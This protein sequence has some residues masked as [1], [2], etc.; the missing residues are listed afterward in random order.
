MTSLRQIP[1]FHIR[2]LDI[3]RSTEERFT[4]NEQHL[5]IDLSLAKCYEYKLEGQYAQACND[6]IKRRLLMYLC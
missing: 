5:F 6:L 3:E 2:A 4:L 1:L